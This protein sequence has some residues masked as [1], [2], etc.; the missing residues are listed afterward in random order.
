MAHNLILVSCNQTRCLIENPGI[1]KS[2]FRT[3]KIHLMGRLDRDDTTPSQKTL[4]LS[5]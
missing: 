3:I 5:E 2:L 1:L 4:S